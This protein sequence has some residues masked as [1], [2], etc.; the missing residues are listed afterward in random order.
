MKIAGRYREVV[1]ARHRDSLEINSTLLG[2]SSW[3]ARTNSLAS[4]TF[5]S[6][7][8]S[9][10][11]VSTASSF[12]RRSRAPF[13]FRSTSFRTLLFP[14]ERGNWLL[15]L[16]DDIPL[17]FLL[18]QAR[19]YSTRLF[20]A[21]DRLIFFRYTRRKAPEN[22]VL[23]ESACYSW[24]TEVAFNLIQSLRSIRGMFILPDPS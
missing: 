18:D 7:S 23:R 11:F 22:G 14:R 24:G 16:A 6:R 19:R 1:A 8:R 2:W 3:I 20:R 4:N 13:V 15:L 12:Y 21:Y 10:I 5:L 9:G 17:F